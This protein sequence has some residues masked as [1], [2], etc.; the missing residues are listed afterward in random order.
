[1]ALEYAQ[2]RTIERRYGWIVAF[3][4]MAMM[5]VGAG[6]T[7]LVIVALKPIAAEFGWPRAVPSLCYS[8]ALLGAGFGGLFWGSISDRIGMVR[9]GHARRLHGRA[10]GLA[11]EPRRGRAHALCRARPVHRSA[12]QRRVHRPAARQHHPLVRSPPRHGGRG[13]RDRS[14]HGRRGLAAD[15]A[16]PDRRLRLAPGL[17]RLRGDRA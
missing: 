6:A 15:P 4:S 5:A 13:G 7:Y 2:P 16:L 8:L 12:R 1:M 9:P 11:R 3:A 10:R 17:L 14:E